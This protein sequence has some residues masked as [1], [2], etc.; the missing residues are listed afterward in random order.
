MADG[1]WKGASPC[2]HYPPFI[3]LTYS[4]ILFPSAVK[5][6]DL[7]LLLRSCFIFGFCCGKTLSLYDIY[8]FSAK[9]QKRTQQQHY[10]SQLTYLCKKKFEQHL[11][12]KNRLLI[13]AMKRIKVQSNTTAIP[14]WTSSGHL[15][16]CSM[17]D[18]QKRTLSSGIYPSILS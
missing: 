11:V 2:Q 14:N 6:L 8:N 17:A 16:R 12:K 18:T 7:A 10:H 1:R 4:G 9:K 3:Q 15:R 5:V 13:A